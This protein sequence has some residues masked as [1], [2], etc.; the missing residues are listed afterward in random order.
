M[1]GT[2][3]RFLKDDAVPTIF[4]FVPET[5]RKRRESSIKR[6]EASSKKM[7]VEEAIV[8]H[9]TRSLSHTENNEDMVFNLSVEK[10]VGTETI[11]TVDKCV[12]Q[13]TV[14]KSVR[15]QY[16]P[17]YCLDTSTVNQ[18]QENTLKIKLPKTKG[19]DKSVNTVLSF[20]PNMKIKIVSD[21]TDKSISDEKEISDAESDVISDKDDPEYFPESQESDTHP[22]QAR[23]LIVRTLLK[24]W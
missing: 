8:D 15:T 1:G 10:S 7:C 20:P 24:T 5:N 12:G 6:A 13:H 11:K 21:E 23:I 22:I 9:E 16:D 17:L 14:Q 4:N 3:R 18:T 2:S 19:K